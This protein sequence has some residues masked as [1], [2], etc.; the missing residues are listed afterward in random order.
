MSA[1][2]LIGIAR[3]NHFLAENR[4]FQ[5]L[6]QDE[7]ILAVSFLLNPDSTRSENKGHHGLSFPDTSDFH[8]RT[9]T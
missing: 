7:F 6:D 5:H 3:E 9:I 8:K 2:I 4:V 1:L